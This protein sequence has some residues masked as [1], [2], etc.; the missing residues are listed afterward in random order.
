MQI[1]DRSYLWGGTDVV[2]TLDMTLYY[3]SERLTGKFNVLSQQSDYSTNSYN[4]KNV[5]LVKLKF[6]LLRLQ[7]V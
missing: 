5:V 7:K 3:H 6:L 1:G 2:R 4:N